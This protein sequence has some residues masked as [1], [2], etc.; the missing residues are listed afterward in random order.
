MGDLAS[1]STKHVTLSRQEPQF[2]SIGQSKLAIE[3]KKYQWYTG[4]FIKKNSKDVKEMV[5][6]RQLF[7]R[8]DECR[9]HNLRRMKEMPEIY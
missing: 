9:L 8:K 3:F 1:T 7:R 5:L 2:R 6:T 4:G